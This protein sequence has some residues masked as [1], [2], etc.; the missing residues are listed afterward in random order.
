MKCHTTYII[1]A[2]LPKTIILVASEAM[3]TSKQP[4]WPRNDVFLVSIGNCWELVPGRGI[5][6]PVP[7]D[8]RAGKR[9]TLVKMSYWGNARAVTG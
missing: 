4:Q 8:Q 5:G 2:S 3:V 9:S 7:P 6:S 1:V